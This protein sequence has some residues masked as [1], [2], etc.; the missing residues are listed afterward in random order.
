M[1]Q[2]NLSDEDYAEFCR[3]YDLYLDGQT[4]SNSLMD[5][6]REQNKIEQFKHDLRRQAAIAKIR[7]MREA[8][9]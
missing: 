4:K 5:T 7:K 2:Y 8:V 3:E 9:K 1:N 6:I